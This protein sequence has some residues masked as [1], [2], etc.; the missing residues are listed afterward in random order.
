MNNFTNF[1]NFSEY[2]ST[3]AVNEASKRINTVVLSVDDINAYLQA[4]KRNIPES[5]ADTI[6]LYVK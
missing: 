6:Y 4:V 1:T 3:I 5:I 2:A